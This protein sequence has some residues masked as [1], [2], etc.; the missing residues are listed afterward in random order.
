MRAPRWLDDAVSDLE[1][2]PG[3][4]RWVTRLRPVS[5]RVAR[6][7]SGE[8]LRGEWLGHAL[9]PLATDLPLGCWISSTALDVVGGRSAA[10]A[11]QRLVGLGLLFVPL[12]AASGLADWNDLDD[13]PRRRV[14]VAHAL[15]NSVVALAY[16]VSW[17]Q[18][19]MG[20]RAGGIA[21]GLLGG[22][23]A[24]VTGYLGGHLSFGSAASV[25]R[26]GIRE[27][28]MV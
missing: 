27:P 28:A 13:P 9:H 26:R 1:G 12:T 18:R 6:D 19:R 8:F 22:L 10:R 24:L 3:L 25:E 21:I 17:R 11:S 2:N 16:L 4:D 14:G 23:L 7:R 5:E 20:N 15:G